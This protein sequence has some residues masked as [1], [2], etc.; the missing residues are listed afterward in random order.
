MEQK[1]VIGQMTNEELLQSEL[2]DY[3]TELSDTKTQLEKL[4]QEKNDL[5]VENQK[6]KNAANIRE[7]RVEHLTNMLDSALQKNSVAH[8]VEVP[9]EEKPQEKFN[10]NDFNIND[11]F[12]KK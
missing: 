2:N 8:R 11:I 9:K 10:I 12:K 1:K 5:V 7:R 3:K 4:I 6:L